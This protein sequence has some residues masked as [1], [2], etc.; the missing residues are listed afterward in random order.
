MKDQ[1]QDALID[2]LIL[3]AASVVLLAGVWW[4]TQSLAHVLAYH[5]V[6]GPPW[7]R[8][9]GYPVYPP[10][11]FFF[12]DVFNRLTGARVFDHAWYPVFAGSA[13]FALGLAMVGL[14]PRGWRAFNERAAGLLCLLPGAAIAFAGL[15][16]STQ[17]MARLAGY[18]ASIGH[19]WFIWHGVPV[20]RPYAFLLWFGRYNKDDPRAFSNASY[21]LV[22]GLALGFF[23][24]VYFW[25]LRSRSHKKTVSHGS[26]HWA[27]GSDL[28]K[29]RLTDNSGVVLGKSRYGERLCHDT[30]EHVLLLAP[31]R[32]GKGL[33][34]IVPT[35][36]TWPDSVVI[37]DIKG[38]NWGITSGYRKSGLN[39]IV[40]RFDPTA[41]A[42]GARFNP[43]EEIRVGTLREVADT[44]N[45]ADILVNPYGEPMQ[46]HWDKTGYDL[47]VG[48]ILHILHSPEIVEKNLATLAVM[49][50]DPERSFDDTLQAMLTAQHDPGLVHGWKTASGKPTAT[51]PVV[52]GAARAMLDRAEDER[53][54]VKSTALATL[55]LYRD[56]LIVINT[57]RSDFRITDLMQHEKP[58]SLYMVI[59]SSEIG[60]TKPLYR[61][62]MNML[63]RKLTESMTFVDGRQV[64]NYRHRLLLLLDEFQALG[65]LEFFEDQLAFIAGYGI[66]ALLVVQNPELIKKYYGINT[67]IFSNCAVRVV[68][69]PNDIDEA[70]HISRSLG[71]K[72]EV[73]T[74][75]S[76]SD[77]GKYLFSCNTSTST[78]EIGRRLMTAREIAEMPDDEEIIFV[79]GHP[80][81]KAGKIRYYKERKFRG[82]VMAAPKVS[83]VC[84]VE[85]A[86]LEAVRAAVRGAEVVAPAATPTSAAVVVV[87]HE[88]EQERTSNP[89]APTDSASVPLQGGEHTRP[90]ESVPEWA[91]KVMAERVEQKKPEDTDDGT[92]GVTV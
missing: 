74:N 1:L 26:A 64:L 24:T 14:R 53:S 27:C 13:V 44:Q 83:D 67:S 39:N 21:Y 72:T 92:G 33:G 31:P 66:K 54:G 47:L 55:S 52:A 9:G 46:N 16:I 90:D 49:L 22:L 75:T 59:P 36:F 58:V 70:E 41:E 3:L 15:W 35:L 48:T 60:R 32:T 81:I 20:Y 69:T 29:A 2:V 80:P 37:S 76:H 18:R 71:E 78:Q 89:A 11:R 10:F 91:G 50:S 42:G 68:Y 23:L 17:V 38:E 4:A 73:V 45:I 19:P 12:W 7:F 77:S 82:R 40:L 84:K 25:K 28:K 86:G 62:I 51:H 63:G 8:L 56:P 34:V 88:V 57:R 79:A 30:E 43:L 5:P 87:A 61:M 6:L 65:K 85:P